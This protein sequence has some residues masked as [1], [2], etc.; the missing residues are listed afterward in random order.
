[1]KYLVVFVALLVVG[2]GCSN[3][4][5]SS[6]GDFSVTTAFSPDPP[7]EGLETL[8]VTLKDPTGAAVKGAD[9]KIATNMPSMS[10]HGPTVTAI[11]HGDGTYAAKMGLQYATSWVFTITA[12]SNGKSAKSEVTENVGSP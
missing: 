9:V 5:A 7:K 2:A 6:Q 4:S 12:S 10:M 1:M 3:K 8:T 11:D